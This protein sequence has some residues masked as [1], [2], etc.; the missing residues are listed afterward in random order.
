MG[1]ESP[2]NQNRFI[3]DAIE[4]SM[5]FTFRDELKIFSVQYVKKMTVGKFNLVIA[6]THALV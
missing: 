6:I 2:T 5:S 4:D 1:F 3:R